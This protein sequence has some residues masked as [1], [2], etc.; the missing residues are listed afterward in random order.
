MIAYLEGTVHGRLPDGAVLL[1]SGGVGYHVR[2]PTP[3]V[4]DLPESGQRVAYHV[5]TVVRADEITL[6][7]F[8]R[9]D[10]K[11]LF[12]LLIS[13]SGIGPKLALAL[14]SAF[15]PAD[16]VTA[17]VTQDI[18]RLSSIPGIGRKTATRLCLELTEKLAKGWVGGAQPAGGTL[19]GQAELLSALTNLG[20]PEKD[21]LLALRQLPPGTAPFAEQLRKALALLGRT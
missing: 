18:A 2:L 21:V 19:G 5:S 8:A 1:T 13:V 7:G 9:P 20:F 17:I 16:V 4:A 3:L 14:L 6:Y 11:A 15:S 10:G 12:E